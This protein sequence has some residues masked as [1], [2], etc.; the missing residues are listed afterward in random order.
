[1]GARVVIEEKQGYGSALRCGI[2]ASKGIY[3]IIGDCDTTYDF[4]NIMPFLT[5]LR[6]D[7]DLVIGNRFSGGIEK[8]AMPFSHKYGIFN[9]DNCAVCQ[10]KWNH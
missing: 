5:E 8:G 2:N 10:N 7:A 4:E 6:Q 3:T 9:G 1:M